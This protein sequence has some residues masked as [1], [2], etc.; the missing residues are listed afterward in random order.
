MENFILEKINKDHKKKF[1]KIN[2]IEYY[3]LG[4]FKI[5]GII[6][7]IDR[8]SNQIVEIKTRKTLDLDKD[9]I[10]HKEKVQALCYMKMYACKTCLFVESGPD[11]IQK[12]TV[13]DWDE[14][15]FNIVIDKLTKFT[16]Y[17]KSLTR[18]EFENM[19]VLV[20]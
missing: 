5:S 19:V 20:Y 7:G 1:V 9:S 4:A 3:D 18:K 2:K 8:D 12:T 14:K 13:V 17:A 6:D 10:S 16:E 15:E 11:G